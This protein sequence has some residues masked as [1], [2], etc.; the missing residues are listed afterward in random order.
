MQA[1]S[2]RPR[3]STGMHTEERG[4][5]ACLGLLRHG[6]DVGEHM[7]T[8]SVLVSERERPRGRVGICIGLQGFNEGFCSIRTCGRAGVGSNRAA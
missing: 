2:P 8:A 4:L 5:E 3:W 1:L 6:S 7:V